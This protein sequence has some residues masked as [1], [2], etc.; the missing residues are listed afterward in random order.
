MSFC[1]G[2]LQLLLS[3]TSETDVSKAVLRKSFFFQARRKPKNGSPVR[4]DAL[5]SFSSYASFHPISFLYEALLR[6]F[7]LPSNLRKG[8]L[9]SNVWKHRFLRHWK[10]CLPI[11]RARPILFDSEVGSVI[12][13][14]VMSR[15]SSSSE[16]FF[17]WS[18]CTWVIRNI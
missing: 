18:C 13:C 1:T 11:S 2:I 17:S 9:P 4:L 6:F 5:N 15:L 8:S 10:D 7:R 16:L 3:T 14:N 12:N